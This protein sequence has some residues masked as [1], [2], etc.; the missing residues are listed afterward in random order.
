MKNLLLRF[1]IV[2]MAFG[3]I[4]TTSAQTHERTQHDRVQ[5]KGVQYTAQQ[6]SSVSLITQGFSSDLIKGAKTELIDED[7]S[8]GTF[9][10]EGWSIL[11]DGQE[12][13]GISDTD[14]AG[15]EAPEVR[16]DW[17]PA[18]DG[19][20]KL[21]SVT[22]NTSGMD[23]LLL[24]FNH[25]L[26]DY[27]SGYTIKVET[28][29]DGSNWNEAWTAYITGSLGPETVMVGI[30]NEDIGSETFQI[31]FTFDGNSD[32]TD[33]WYIDDV[34]LFEGVDKDVSTTAIMGFDAINNLGLEITP[35]A[36]IF[37]NGTETVSFDV[38]IRINDGTT[39]VYTSSATVTDLGFTEEQTVTFD[40]WTTTVEGTFTAY[41]TTMLDGD[42][43]PDND[44]MSFSFTVMDG[45][46]LYQ[47]FYNGIDGWEVMG[48]GAG[49]WNV[50]A[51][52]FA[53]SSAPE[54]EF[55]WSPVFEG[56]SRFVSPMVNTSA[57]TELSL[58]FKHYLDYYSGGYNLKIETTSDGGTTW[59]EI[60]AI[61]DVQEG[62]DAE[63]IVFGFSNSDVGSET[64]QM[65]FTFE[66][67]SDLINN[68][69]IDDIILR[70]PPQKDVSPYDMTGFFS[71]MNKDAEVTPGVSVI[72]LSG[73][74]ASFDVKMTINN[75]STDVYESVQTIEDLAGFEE[76]TIDF[77]MWITEVG[78]MK[79]TVITL[80]EGD[81]NAAND[82]VMYN[83]IVIDGIF[84]NMVVAEDFTGA[85]CG[86][87]P[88]AAMGIDDLIHQGYDVAAVA[89]H[90]GDDYATDEAGVREDFYGIT[91][92]PTVKFDGVE[93]YIGGSATE[94]M[95]DTYI[96]I[97]EQRMAM[98][99]PIKV[100]LED[101]NFS[102]TTFTANVNIDP[103]STFPDG[104]IVLYAIITESHI[105][106]T[107]Q[108]LFEMN[109]VDRAMFNGENGLPI[110]LTLG[111]QDIPIE[112]VLGD[113][114]VPELCEVVVFVQHTSTK[115]VFNA[116][117]VQ[118]KEIE[119]FADIMVTTTDNNGFALEGVL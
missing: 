96:P 71:M 42:E 56:L 47:N 2:F 25:K 45:V 33:G 1:I 85:W 48:D 76:T 90:N 62:F 86:F 78:N 54:L 94:S 31:A 65:A 116:D 22:V 69:N 57:Y 67:N 115:E 84:R 79:A 98:P 95:I 9:P 112:F 105:A 88:G 97:I 75:G 61:Y 93:E 18:F 104:E 83:F 91:G 114:W 81:A 16:F 63:A 39:D 101:V 40:S 13:W 80:L 11:G 66:G 28:S 60:W 29:S 119:D 103:I 5:Q 10:P 110:D 51:T 23:A 8:S 20:S 53:G 109:Y 17:S 59:N 4:A 46:L 117:K 6:A 113:D 52:D 58:D 72:N 26:Y 73:A 24:S 70:E 118:V 100:D 32:F 99:T 41:V 35:A 15:S 64:F 111:Q 36:K 30:E 107:W 44:E 106:E 19:N 89:F 37:N 49:N 55:G 27:A 50:K 7:F 77:D 102:G 82:T 21:V 38:D 92:F 3:L 68:W 43:N 87:C 12:N 14:Y 108:T 34:L 74:A